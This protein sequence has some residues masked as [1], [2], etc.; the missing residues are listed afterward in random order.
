MARPSS[1]P[2]LLPTTT[3]RDESLR[4]EPLPPS[5]NQDGPFKYYFIW[6][7]RFVVFSLTGSTSLRLCNLILQ[8]LCHITVSS[9][10]LIVYIILVT[11]LELVLVYPLT[12]ALLGTILGQPRFFGR[13]LYKGWG[14]WILPLSTQQK[15]IQSGWL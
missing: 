12:L 4:L 9:V 6:C 13:V 10:G 2:L 14:Q 1:E 11:G 7:W 8:H 5:Y 3:S 15:W